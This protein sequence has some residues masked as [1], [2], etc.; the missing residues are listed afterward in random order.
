MILS[1]VSAISDMV[2]P[3]VLMT[4]STIFANGLMTVAGNISENVV[5][6]NFRRIRSAILIIGVAVAL[7]A[8]SVTAIAGT[9][10]CLA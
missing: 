9:W 5:A 8:L 1:P 10:E 4:L 7:F 3:V 2:A 6:L